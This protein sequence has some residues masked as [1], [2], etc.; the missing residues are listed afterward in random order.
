[1][2]NSGALAIVEGCG[3]NGCEY[4]TGGSAI[5]LGNIGDNFGA[6]MTGGSAFIYSDQKNISDLM[7][8]E[9]ISLYEVDNQ[10]WKNHLLDL[11]KDFYKETKSKR[12]EFIIENYDSEI[13]KFAHVVP[14][15]VI[16]KLEFPVTK[17]SK[18]A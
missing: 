8:M 12:T 9:T 18:I 7:N 17:K 6:G 3:A 13:K 16:D 4:M 10:D 11:L 2:R 14:D 15:E 1:M 5:I